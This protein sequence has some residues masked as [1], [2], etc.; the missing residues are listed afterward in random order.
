MDSDLIK[1]TQINNES[2]LK[3]AKIKGQF[4]I[5]F[6]KY[7]NR[8]R[9]S[10]IFEFWLW[11]LDIILSI[12]GEKGFLDFLKSEINSPYSFASFLDNRTYNN[13]FIKIKN[14]KYKFLIINLISKNLYFPGYDQK[15][16]FEKIKG[17]L[18]NKFIKYLPI[19]KDNNLKNK[20]VHLV[21]NYFSDLKLDNLETYLNNKLPLIFCSKPIYNIKEPICIKC[22]AQVFLEFS[23][24]ENI[25]LIN[26]NIYIK[27]YQHGGGSGTFLNDF[28]AEYE[29]S[30]CNKFFGWGLSEINIKQNRYKKIKKNN[31]SQKRIIWIESNSVSKFS[32][33]IQP[34]FYINSNNNKIMEYIYKEIKTLN[35]KYFNLIHPR[36]PF[37]RYKKYRDE[38]ILGTRINVEKIFFKNDIAIFDNSCSSLI[39]FFIENEM[40][41]LQVISRNEYD[42]FT[43]M[44]KDWFEILYKN[45]LS[46]Y[47]DEEGKLSSSLNKII[48]NDYE[49]PKDV[50]NYNK[51]IFQC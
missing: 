44:Q 51:T 5:L 9:I 21:I 15:N 10:K 25:F 45:D 6:E 34:N 4:N 8:D 42:N 32:L 12:Y 22:S 36:F 47:N 14:K 26:S 33:M 17:R 39:H 28:Y 18:S 1:S 16:L 49:I 40:S 31:L 30:L 43:S 27:G 38:I 50:I 13:S 7:D 11:N 3:Y 29:K 41:F 24:Y 2:K 20:I 23:N 19:Q 37:K 46:F 48:N 35:Y